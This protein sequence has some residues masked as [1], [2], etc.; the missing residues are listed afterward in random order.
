MLIAPMV[1]RPSLPPRQRVRSENLRVRA[2]RPSLLDL[3]FTADPWIEMSADGRLVMR[4]GGY[5]IA[6][7]NGSP[8]DLP[9]LNGLLDRIRHR[10]P[11]CRAFCG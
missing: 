2:T 9:V 7:I 10:R 5:S 8:I 1:V 4:L 3:R 11:R 6:S